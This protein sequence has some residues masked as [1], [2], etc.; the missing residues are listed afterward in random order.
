MSWVHPGH[1]WELPNTMSSSYH[2]SSQHDPLLSGRCGPELLF[3]CSHAFGSLQVQISRKFSKTLSHRGFRNT[4]SVSTV[5]T[6]PHTS[7][8]LG[9]YVD[10]SLLG[11]VA[12]RSWVA[13]TWF[14]NIPSTKSY[15]TV[16]CSRHS[17]LR[18]YR[19]NEPEQILSTRHPP[20]LTAR[21]RS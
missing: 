9:S 8:K 4:H 10:T 5:S 18:I 12:A 17:I 16:F 19:R 13:Y 6:H 1:I 15:S 11:L 14:W 2:Q 20:G 21:H 3:G 7:G